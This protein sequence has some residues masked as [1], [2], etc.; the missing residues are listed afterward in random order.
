MPEAVIIDAIRTPIGCAV[1]A[2]LKDVRTDDLSAVPLRVPGTIGLE[3]M[4]VAG[5]VGQT[6]ILERLN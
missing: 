3:T 2:S 1:E 4:C 5:G 6:M